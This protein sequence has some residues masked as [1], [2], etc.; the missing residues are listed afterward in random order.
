MMD[1][2]DYFAELLVAG[3]FAV[4]AWNVNSLIDED[5]DSSS[6]RMSAVVSRTSGREG[7]SDERRSS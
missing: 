6:P 1:A 3:R 4:A 2:R 7:E 5:F